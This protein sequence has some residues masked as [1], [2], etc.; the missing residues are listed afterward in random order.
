MCIQIIIQLTKTELSFSLLHFK[1][2]RLQLPIGDENLHFRLKSEIDKLM[3]DSTTILNQNQ[4]RVL[5][6]L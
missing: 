3:G 4:T 2:R 6:V 5:S 1:F